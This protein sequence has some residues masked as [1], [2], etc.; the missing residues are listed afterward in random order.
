[1][2]L[3]PGGVDEDPV[4]L[5]AAELS[6][7]LPTRLDRGLLL[8]LLSLGMGV[9]DVAH[10]V[11]PVGEGLGALAAPRGGLLLVQLAPLVA[12]LVVRAI[13]FVS[14]RLVAIPRYMQGGKSINDR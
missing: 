11:V 10:Q 5:L 2:L 13:L 3:Q 1:M 6:P 14:K 7:L 4:A 9:P 12:T 8:L